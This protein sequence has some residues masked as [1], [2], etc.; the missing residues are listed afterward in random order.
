MSV[1]KLLKGKEG[2]LV[3]SNQKKEEEEK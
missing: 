2:R 1:K 3:D